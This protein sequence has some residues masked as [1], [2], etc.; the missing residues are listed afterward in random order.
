VAGFDGAANDVLMRRLGIGRFHC[1]T[2]DVPPGRGANHS[3][4][5]SNSNC[6]EEGSPKPEDTLQAGTRWLTG[7]EFFEDFPVAQGGDAIDTLQTNEL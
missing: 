1:G 2:H 4:A 7:C 5:C 6:H 3:T